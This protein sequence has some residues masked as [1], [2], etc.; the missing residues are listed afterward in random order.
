MYRVSG[1]CCVPEPSGAG[2]L[3]GD[4]LFAHFI[5]SSI[6]EP[7]LRNHAAFLQALKLSTWCCSSFLEA[8][9]LGL[10]DPEFLIELYRT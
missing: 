10:R 2:Y 8:G 7:S 4:I 6:K 1:E 9:W 3:V 5:L